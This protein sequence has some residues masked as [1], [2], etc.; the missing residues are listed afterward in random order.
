MMREEKNPAILCRDVRKAFGPVMAVQGL[1]L[2]VFP[3]ELYALLGVNGAGKT[4][5]IKLLTGLLRPDGGTLEILGKKLPQEMEAMRRITAVSPQETAVAGLLTVRENL[6]LMARVHGLGKKEG[7]KRA[8]DTINALGLQPVKDRRA[9]TLSGGWQRRLSIAMALIGEPQVLYLDEPTLGLDVLARRELWREVESL[10]GKTTIV[11]TT[12]YMEE[13]QALS[14]RV[15]IMAGGRLLEEGTVE[16]LC[17]KTGG[18]NLEEAFVRLV[19]EEP[20]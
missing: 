19:E 11:L 3:G 14:D 8:S 12:H 6:E 16:E 9:K 20:S 5:T 7:R 4:T 15:G 17:E 2:Q 13:A 1:N 10:K 18:E